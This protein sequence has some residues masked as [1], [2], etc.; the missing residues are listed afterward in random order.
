MNSRNRKQRREAIDA[1]HGDWT[2]EVQGR[3][4]DRFWG[5]LLQELP[6]EG[7]APPAREAAQAI[8]DNLKEAR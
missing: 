5:V 1:K 6:M 4:F 2:H 7:R 3:A 8:A